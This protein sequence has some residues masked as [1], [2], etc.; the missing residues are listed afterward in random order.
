MFATLSLIIGQ[1][2]TLVLKLTTENVYGSEK[3]TIHSAL[4]TSI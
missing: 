3:K 2:T 4:M 1:F